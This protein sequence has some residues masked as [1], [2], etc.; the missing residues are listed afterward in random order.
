[1][2]EPAAS[3]LQSDREVTEPHGHRLTQGPHTS[4]I[5]RNRFEI[6]FFSSLEALGFVD[7]ST[8]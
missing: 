5:K 7:S 8:F 3:A 6:I 2:A 4:G 1:M